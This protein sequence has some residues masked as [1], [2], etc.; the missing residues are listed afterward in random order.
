MKITNTQKTMNKKILLLGLAF[1]GSFVAG[2]DEKVPVSPRPPDGSNPNVSGTPQERIERLKT[3]TS[4]PPEERE[5]RIQWI[6]TKNNI[7]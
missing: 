1:I 6:K 7:K 2:C 3:D 4:L 5:R